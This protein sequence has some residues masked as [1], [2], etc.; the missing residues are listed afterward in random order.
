MGKTLEELKN[1]EKKS[2]GPGPWIC[3]H[4]LTNIKHELRSDSVETGIES[5]DPGAIGLEMDTERDTSETDTC[6]EGETPMK[7]DTDVDSGVGG[8][9]T[10]HII[11]IDSLSNDELR[12]LM[13][14]I[15]Q[16]I[17][18]DVRSDA[19]K[20]SQQ[21]S[22][23]DFLTIN[24]VEYVQER[25]AVLVGFLMGIANESMHSLM[26]Q[27]NSAYRLAKTL[28]SV[29]GLT[30]TNIILPIHFRESILQYSLSPSRLAL[31]VHGSSGCHASYKT[32]QG[33]LEKLPK[34]STLTL[35]GDLIAIF[36]NNQVLSRAWHVKVEGKFS[37]SIITMVLYFEIDGIGKLQWKTELKPGQWLFNN[38]EKSNKRVG[39]I[40]EFGKLAEVSDVHYKEFLFP[41]LSEVLDEVAADQDVSEDGVKDDIDD[42]VSLELSRETYKECFNPDCTATPEEKKSV[43]KNKINCPFC[44]KN[45]KQ[46]QQSITGTGESTFAKPKDRHQKSAK[47]K[48]FRVTYDPEMEKSHSQQIRLD[49]SE[50]HIPPKSYLS[51]PVFVN[52][53]SYSSVITILRNIGKKA[54][55]KKYGSGDREWIVVYCDGSPLNLCM[56]VILSTYSCNTCSEVVTGFG[57]IETHMKA[58]HGIDIYEQPDCA[59]LEFDWVLMCPGPGH[60][61]MN[62]LH[63]LVELC[64]SLFWESMCRDFNF[65][66][67]NALKG[68]RR[69][70][71]HHKGWELLRIA[72]MAM[73]KELVVPYV[74]SEL[75]SDAE[76]KITPDGFMKFVMTQE[77]DATYALVADIVI[78]IFSAIFMY[79]KGI[80]DNNPS[81]VMAGRAVFAK[82]W[83]ARNHPL[84]RELEMSDSISFARMPQQVRDFVCKTWSINTSGIPGTGEGPDFKLE[85][86]NKVI[87][88]W[89]PSVPYGP[90]WVR[91]CANEAS[92]SEL[93]KKVFHDIGIKDSQHK[94]VRQE[95]NLDAEVKKFRTSLRKAEYVS[96]PK[97]RP[98]VVSLDGAVLDKDL[99]KLCGL[100][101][102]KRSKFFDAY[103]NYEASRNVTRTGVPFKEE[104][105]FVTTQERD[106]FNSI[107]NKSI[108]DIKTMITEKLAQIE[109]QNILE[110]YEDVF[111]EEVA[112][113]GVKK[114]D[115]VNLYQELVDH[116][117]KDDV[118]YLVLITANTTTLLIKTLGRMQGG[119]SDSLTAVST[120]KIIT[121]LFCS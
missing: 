109:D 11:D 4:C 78:Q 22:L 56:R 34:T 13:Y 50:E 23:Q 30:T 27:T 91:A 87:Q 121:E 62:M 57:K 25:N 35:S 42:L 96:K 49:P 53:S 24:P 69:V 116:L 95:S 40:R 41:F 110:G 58:N 1:S 76:P 107:E 112:R 12:D 2:K 117:S 64:W 66:S 118:W 28:E 102:E 16:K 113:K 89:V 46:S 101:R 65:R 47:G 75:S 120:G 43:P 114:Q 73:I 71:D 108:S 10:A 74:R 115:F 36:D 18:V 103:I 97:A 67:E 90:D 100:A 15:G 105:V 6:S 48:T 111:R 81:F 51:E 82:L 104:P 45:L 14:R 119:E 92:L 26:T 60:I 59:D 8:D 63:T 32:V 20:A 29:M 106:Q 37:C 83:S 5:K 61:E 31:Q 86:K 84:Y 99:V 98:T 55:V 44:K 38:D 88:N 70:S 9:T 80:R 21:N 17:S 77:E 33:W 79:R 72:N 85:E 94:E 7:V 93:R 68:Q 39:Y 19:I 54:G 3:S 52:P